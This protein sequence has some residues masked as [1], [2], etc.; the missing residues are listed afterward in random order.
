MFDLFRWNASEGMMLV[1]PVGARGSGSTTSTSAFCLPWG[2]ER[3]EDFVGHPVSGVVP[4]T[5]IRRVLETGKPIL[6]DPAHQPRGHL[7]VS[8]IPLRDEARGGDWALGIV[9]FDQ[10]EITCNRSSPVR[11]CSATRMRAWGTSRAA[12]VVVS[13]VRHSGTRWSVQ[14]NQRASAW[15]SSA[16]PHGRRS[17]SAQC[18]CCETGQA[19]KELLAQGI[20]AASAARAG[21]PL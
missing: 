1:D 5:Q 12:Q 20:H 16:R 13:S 21:L 18:C 3:E 11:C 8:R 6:I 10:P 17:R 14:G 4:N 2:F 7:V 9:L 15:R 19:G